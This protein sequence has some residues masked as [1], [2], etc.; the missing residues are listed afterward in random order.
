M[1]VI[2]WI[3]LGLLFTAILLYVIA[4]IKKIKYLDG[5]T[6]LFFIPL[7]CSFIIRLLNNYLPDSNHILFISCF[8]VTFISLREFFI[9]FNFHRLMKYASQGLYLLNLISWIQLYKT[10][11]YIYRPSA[12][13][14]LIVIVLFA[15]LFGFLCIM[16]GKDKLKYALT[17][18]VPF[19]LIGYLNYSAVISHINLHDFSTV[20]LLA[21]TLLLAADFVFYSIQTTKPIEINR[22][23]EHALRIGLITLAQFF[24]TASG[25]FMIK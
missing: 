9:W 11:F 3:L 15:A 5:I 21:G 19:I 14:T 23:L 1:I 25:L 7:S 10:T 4:N 16:M 18:I 24:I 20:V 22:K 2:D 13:W 6:A 17:C 8:A 12:I